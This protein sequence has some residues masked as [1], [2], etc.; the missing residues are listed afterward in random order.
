VEI[1]EKTARGDPHRGIL[2]LSQPKPSVNRERDHRG[3]AAGGTIRAWTPRAWESIAR[4]TLSR[5]RPLATQFLQHH[6]AHL[7]RRRPR[8]RVPA[9]ARPFPVLGPGNQPATHGIG[10]QAFDHRSQG[11]GPRNVAV[12]TTARLPKQVTR[13]RVSRA[14]PPH[15]RPLSPAG[16]ACTTARRGRA[17]ARGGPDRFLLPT[18]LTDKNAGLRDLGYLSCP[19]QGPC[20][21]R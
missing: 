19:L 12:V 8:P 21:S 5:A 2:D 3:S 10:M 11:R 20:R 15:P 7:N 13:P 4:E 14:R 18:D 6:R 1:N 16:A 9:C 17:G